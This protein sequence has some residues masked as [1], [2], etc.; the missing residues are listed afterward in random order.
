MLPEQRELARSFYQLY[1]EKE[2]IRNHSMHGELL[3]RRPERSSLSVSISLVCAHVRMVLS[4]RTVSQLSSSV[5][6]RLMLSLTSNRRCSSAEI[7]CNVSSSKIVSSG[8]ALVASQPPE[9]ARVRPCLR[10][11]LHECLRGDVDGDEVLD[12]RVEM[13]VTDAFRGRIC[14]R[15]LQSSSCCSCSSTYFCNTKL[16][17][18]VLAQLILTGQLWWQQGSVGS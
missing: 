11:P 17:V 3:R 16:Q 9:Q 1:S 7:S 8:Q 6:A 15:W 18:S 13:L 12:D 2:K 10:S 4:P 14:S 5:N